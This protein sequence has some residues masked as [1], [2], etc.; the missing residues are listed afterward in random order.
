MAE[1]PTK[2]QR[3]LENKIS[4]WENHLRVRRDSID[5]NYDLKIKSA[6]TD[7]QRKHYTDAKAAA[8]AT[9]ADLEASRVEPMRAEYRRIMG[10]D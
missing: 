5:A 9:V 4:Y 2:K 3:S 1:N 8:L 10:L 7:A 6:R